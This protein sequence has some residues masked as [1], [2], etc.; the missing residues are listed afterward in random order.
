[1]DKRLIE[2]IESYSHGL[3][4]VKEM[5]PVTFYLKGKQA[6]VLGLIS[7]DIQPLEP[8]TVNQT[9]NGLVID[10]DKIMPILIN[11]IKDLSNEVESLKKVKAKK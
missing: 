9:L 3:N 5:Q 2:Q 10:Y 1:M 7:Q 11:A 4:L 6:K 8:K